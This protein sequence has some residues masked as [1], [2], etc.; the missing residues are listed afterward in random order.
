[1][2]RLLFFGLPTGRNAQETETPKALPFC[3]G[4]RS[5][6]NATQAIRISSP[7]SNHFSDCR[8]H[9]PCGQ[10]VTRKARRTIAGPRSDASPDEA[11]KGSRTKPA[12]RRA[13]ATETAA[14]P[15]LAQRARAGRQERPLPRGG[16]AP[17][18]QAAFSIRATN[19]AI[20][21]VLWR[22]PYRMPDI[23]PFGRANG[24]GTGSRSLRGRR[25]Q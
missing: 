7:F 24:H 23:T 19:R 12:R 13:G 1:M 22:D 8:E 14:G 4:W 11:L 10:A 5:A 15:D 6:S 20:L 17:P 21:P 16:V 18:W 25:S 3:V 2:K 9:G